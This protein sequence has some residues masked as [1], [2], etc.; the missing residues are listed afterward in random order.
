MSVNRLWEF[1]TFQEIEEVPHS[2]VGNIGI[3]ITDGNFSWD[4]KVIKKKGIMIA[5]Y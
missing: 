5:H 1:L 2:K 3:K 4:G